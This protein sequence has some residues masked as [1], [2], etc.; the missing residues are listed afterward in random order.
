MTAKKSTKKESKIAFVKRS[1]AERHPFAVPLVTIGVLFVGSLFAF[2]MYGGQVVQPGDTKIIRFHSEGQNQSIITRAKTVQEFL[3]RSSIKI[4]E[5]DVVEPV[6]DSEITSQEFSVNLYKAKPVTVIDE[7]GNKT[8]TKTADTIPE[9]IAKKA[10]YALYPEDIV[11]VTEP[12]K[13]LQQGIIGTN[14]SINRATPIKMNLFGTT[15]EIRTHADTVAELAKERGIS[16]D[17]KSVLPAP[18]TKLKDNELVFIT[19]PGKQLTTAEE[20]I[21]YE[22]ENLTDPALALGV[23]EVRS[24]GAVGRRATVYEV[25]PNGQKTLL[26]QIVI[27]N[28]VKR[29]VAKG[30]KVTAPNVS[31][32]G[33]RATLMAQAGIPSDQYGSVDYIISHESGWR[34]AARSANNCIGLGQKCNAASLISACPNWETD[35]VCQLGHFNSYAVGRYG[36]WNQAYAFWTVNRWW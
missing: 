20:T 15:Y 23:T 36:S 14:I 7:N 29:V 10:G 4:A 25:L 1:F 21:P 24:P 9:V 31:V 34:P 3:D 28:P 6:A 33:D 35:P 8:I 5:G 18:N 22:Q 32:A 26:Q 13:S 16:F 17:D 11:K 2:F 27:S 30:K 12:D 19:Q